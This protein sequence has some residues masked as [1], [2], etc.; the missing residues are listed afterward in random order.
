MTDHVLQIKAMF[1]LRQ[2]LSE[3]DWRKAVG[4]G[5]SGNFSRANKRI[6]KVIL[7]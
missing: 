7:P 5:M 1:E 6:N 2:I 3:E 4:V